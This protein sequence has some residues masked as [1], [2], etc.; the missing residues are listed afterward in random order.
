[1]Y[2]CTDIEP[3]YRAKSRFTMPLVV[4]PGPEE[5][6]N[7]TPYLEGTLESFRACGPGGR[8]MNQTFQPPRQTLSTNRMHC[9]GERPLIVKEHKAPDPAA[10]NGWITEEFRHMPILTAFE[11]DTPARSK[12]AKFTSHACYMG[13]CGLCTLQGTMKDPSGRKTPAVHFRGYSKETRCGLRVPGVPNVMAKCGDPAIKLTQAQQLAR[14]S[15]VDKRQ[16]E[17]LDEATRKA[18]WDSSEAGSMGTSTVMTKLSYTRYDRTFVC[19]VAHALLFGVVKDF[20]KLLLCKGRDGQYWYRLPTAVQKAMADR[21]SD[22]VSTLDQD[23]SYSCI[24]M[25]KGKWVM[26]DWLV[27][28][29]VWSVYI[30]MRPADNKVVPSCHG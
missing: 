21:A 29:E 10:P 27:W 22:L 28:C 4:I 25:K 23:R 26:M 17:R 9:A 5:P 6:K 15:M 3:L 30:M 11:A 8:S 20:W 16:D 1:L 19:S 12:L 7:M 24:V 18:G 13:A 2:R 14:D